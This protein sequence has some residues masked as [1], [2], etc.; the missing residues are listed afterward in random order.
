MSSSDQAN[1]D[2]TNLNLFVDGLRDLLRSSRVLLSK[3]G[4]VFIGEDFKGL[5]EI[6][7]GRVYVTNEDEIV[8]VS[9]DED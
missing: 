5:L 6:R 8:A 7:D 1:K 2:R 3:E 9:S 4:L